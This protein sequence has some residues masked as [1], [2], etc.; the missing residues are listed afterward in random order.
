MANYGITAIKIVRQA[1]NPVEGKDR[2]KSRTRKK[3]KKK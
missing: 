3:R 1:N 2:S